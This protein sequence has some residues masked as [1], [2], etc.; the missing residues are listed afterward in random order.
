MTGN[1]RLLHL[2]VNGDDDSTGIYQL[3]VLPDRRKNGRDKTCEMIGATEGMS[4]T[5][6][7]SNACAY[8]SST[9][10]AV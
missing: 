10:T 3:L 1:N 6:Q 2:G 8:E 7:L 4:Q 5:K 9:H